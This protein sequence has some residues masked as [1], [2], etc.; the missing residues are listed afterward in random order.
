MAP[1]TAPPTLRLRPEEVIGSGRPLR[2]ASM[3][4]WGD[5]AEVDAAHG[6]EDGQVKGGHPRFSIGLVTRRGYLENT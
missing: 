6:C 5:G 2:T 4:L 1:L 3:C